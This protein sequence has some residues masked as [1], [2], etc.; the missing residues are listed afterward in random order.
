MARVDFCHNGLVSENGA[1]ST[2]SVAM[3][4]NLR[5]AA[6]ADGTELHYLPGEQYT[7]IEV[8][9]GSISGKFATSATLRRRT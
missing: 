3:N 8:N 1:Y 9:G 5:I 4:G 7:L 2:N 6:R